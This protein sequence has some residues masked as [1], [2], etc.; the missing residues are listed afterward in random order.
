MV[1]FHF[2]NFLKIIFQNR[3]LKTKILGSGYVL[4]DDKDFVFALLY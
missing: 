2:K 3:V 4:D 1:V